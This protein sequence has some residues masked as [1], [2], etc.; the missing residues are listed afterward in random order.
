[1]F[2]SNLIIS[3]RYANDNLL[4]NCFRKIEVKDIRHYSNKGFVVKKG[5]DF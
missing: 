1:M 3:G 5:I 2:D 4:E